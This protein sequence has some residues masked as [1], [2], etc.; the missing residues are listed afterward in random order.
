MGGNRIR[1]KNADVELDTLE[2]G[3]AND[4]LKFN[5]TRQRIVDLCNAEF[6]DDP[7]EETKAYS[8]FHRALDGQETYKG[9]VREISD[10]WYSQAA[11]PRKYLPSE[12]PGEDLAAWMAQ[13]A[14]ATWWYNTLDLDMTQSTL[15]AWFSGRGKQERSDVRE[16]VQAW[17]QRLKDAAD[18]A[19]RRSAA[20]ERNRYGGKEKTIQSWD[21]WCK[22]LLE[23]GDLLEDVREKFMAERLLWETH[24]FDPVMID[25]ADPQCLELGIWSETIDFARSHAERDWEAL[26]ER[27]FCCA[28]SR[29][30]VEFD[31]TPYFSEKVWGDRRNEDCPKDINVALY[32]LHYRTR[33]QRFWDAEKRCVEEQR[34]I[35][36]VSKDGENWFEPTERQQQGWDRGFDH[37]LVA[38]DAGEDTDNLYTQELNEADGRVS[39]LE[40]ELSGTWSQRSDD[41]IEAQLSEARDAA[42]FAYGNTGYQASVSSKAM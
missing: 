18:V 22:D 34:E 14:K 36:A 31:A 41:A 40:R 9:I 6:E 13:F 1:K 35:V 17:W 23:D 30:P 12:G 11:H 24:S 3:I 32:K 39:R 21:T 2:N 37:W 33:H 8:S 42:N 28:V 38:M 15:N 25:L 7:L 26:V 10:L 20:G 4:L 5:L 19:E 27:D 29:T 16:Q